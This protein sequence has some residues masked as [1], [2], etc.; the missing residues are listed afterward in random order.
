MT[1][2]LTLPRTDLG[3][4]QRM[5]LSESESL[6]R[7]DF[8]R[9]LRK[10]GNFTRVFGGI[11]LRAYQQAAANAIVNSVLLNQGLSIVVMFPRQSGKNLMQAQLE[12]YLMA[13]LS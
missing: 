4:C 7:P 8:L 10:V 1:E 5:R 3:Y 12:V 2:A 11:K 6:N 13:L 9:S